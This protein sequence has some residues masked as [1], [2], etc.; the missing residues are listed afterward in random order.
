M[1]VAEVK[2][3]KGET[4][5][6]AE[7]PDHIYRVAV[8]KSIL[9]EVVTM[10]L[11]ARRRGTASVKTRAEV[12]GSTAKL[13][14]QKGTGRARR[15]DIK[16]PLLKGGGV[17]FGPSPRS[18]EKKVPKKVRKLALKMAL[19]SKVQEDALTVVDAFSLE[20]IKTKDFIRAIESLGLQNVL[21]VT[22]DEN[23]ELELSARNVSDVKV[24]RWEGLN[25]Y[26]VLKYRHLVLLETVLASI[27]GRLN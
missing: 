24:L 15:G 14:R 12:K 3:I 11:A 13:F 2:N 10:Q 20:R 23:R 18:Y 9:N 21:I 19:S 25:V 7:L 5:S 26:D 22:G 4:V 16:S 27:E 17:A 1:A 6:Q 8:N